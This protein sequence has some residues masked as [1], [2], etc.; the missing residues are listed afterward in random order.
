MRYMQRS[1]GVWRKERM[2]LVS[3]IMNYFIRKVAFEFGLE[4]W[5]TL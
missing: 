3:R 5:I 2:Y 4:E 1:L